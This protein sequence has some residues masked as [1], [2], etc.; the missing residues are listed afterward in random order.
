MDLGLTG[1]SALVTGSTLGIGKVI[2]TCLAREGANVLIHGRDEQ[3]V[4][5]TIADIQRLHPHAR[6]QPAVADLK[7]E[8]GCEALL[9]Q[10]PAL[11][12]LINNLGI[13]D[14]AEPFDIPDKAWFELFEVNVMTGVRLSRHYLKDMIARGEGRVI[15]IVSEGAIM[16]SLEMVHHSATQTMQLSVSRGLAELTAGTRATVNAVLTGPALIEGVEPL[17]RMMSLQAKTSIAETEKRF[18]KENHPTSIIQ[19]LIRPEEIGD[20]VA[21]LSSPLSGAING[22]AL[23]IDG[24][25]VRSVF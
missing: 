18:M 19:R 15:F 24:G 3:K 11:D 10:H 1:K 21:F 12:I 13:F 6:L 5:S 4:R 22:A 17:L 7:N 8:V 25:L 23:R 14:P 9:R 20:F 16:P 2:A